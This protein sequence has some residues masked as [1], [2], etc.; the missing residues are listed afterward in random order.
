[1]ITLVWFALVMTAQGPQSLQLSENNTFE[2]TAIC[3]AFGEA[4]TPRVQDYMRGVLKADW[5]DNIPVRFECDS[6]KPA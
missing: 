3:E 5:D 6:G 1:M 4:Y 2:T